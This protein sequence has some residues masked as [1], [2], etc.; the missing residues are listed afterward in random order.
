[1]FQYIYRHCLG[2]VRITGNNRGDSMQQN[3]SSH[4]RRQ[5][6]VRK[7]QQRLPQTTLD[8]ALN[9]RL[10]CFT[11]SQLWYC[12]IR[13]PS[14]AKVNFNLKIL[15]LKHYR[16]P[17]EPFKQSKQV[18]SKIVRKEIT[19]PSRVYHKNRPLSS[20]TF[21]KHSPMLDAICTQQYSQQ[22]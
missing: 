16:H 5:A 7:P 1:M 19:Q 11:S 2:D 12:N 15:Q 20:M 4:A 18:C 21:K 10:C 6:G 17:L 3:N 22:T 8:G 13:N 9:P 14:I